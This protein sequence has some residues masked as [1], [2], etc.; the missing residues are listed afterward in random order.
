MKP[1]RRQH[2]T[3]PGIGSPPEAATSDGGD[4]ADE[5]SSP[6]RVA[7]CVDTRDGPGRERVAGIYE[8]AMKRGWELFLVRHDGAQAIASLLDLG[9]HG[10]I[11]FDRHPSFHRALRDRGVFCVETSARNLPLSDTSVHVDDDALGR[12]AAEHLLACGLEHFAYC[13]PMHRVAPAARRGASFVAH[14]RSRGADAAL[15]E[16]FPKSGDAPLSAL[17]TWLRSLPRPLGLLAFDDK[18]AEGVLCAARM[19]G[20]AVPGDLAVVGVGNDELVCELV[21]PKLTS[22]AL[23]TREIGRLAAGIVGAHRAGEPFP[24][25]QALPPTEIVVRAS[26][27]RL[28][29][30]DPAATAAIELIRTNAHRSFGTDQIV[31]ALGV[32]RRT[33]ERRFQAATGSTIHDY[34]V[35]HRMAHARRILR[36]TNDSLTEVARQCGYT[37]LSSFTRMFTERVGCHPD[38]YRRRSRALD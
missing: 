9:L 10:A 23:P 16:H 18:A 22:I 30:A 14:V 11:L 20:L 8:Y 6:L 21:H 27:E 29:H 5:R 31:A 25:L 36:R 2:P 13:G 37:V 12:L 3:S 17:R 34:I 38:A 1:Q 19:A 24:V 15:F 33:L 7:V 32:P 28:V 4:H 35:D 26:S